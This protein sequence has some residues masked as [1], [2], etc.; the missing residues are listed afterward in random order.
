VVVGQLD[1]LEVIGGHVGNAGRVG[2]FARI[3]AAHGHHGHAAVRQRRATAGSSKSAMMPSPCQ[4]SMPGRR[5]RKS[6]SRNRSHDARGVQV[7]GDARDD[8]AVID[9][10]PV[11]QQR[12]VV[13]GR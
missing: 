3:R 12:D 4:R 1:D 11:E 10:V 2:V 9:L 13:R 7:G 5:Q 8:V 6:S